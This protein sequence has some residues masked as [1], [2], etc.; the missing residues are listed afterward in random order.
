M[1]T[2]S[3]E[4]DKLLEE[5]EVLTGELQKAMR[6]ITVLESR[7][8]DANCRCKNVAGELKLIQVSLAALRQEKQKSQRQKI[9]AVQWLDHWKSRT[10]MSC[11][12]VNAPIQCAGELLELAEFSL[13]D[14][15]SA[16]CNFS[17]S[18]KIGEGGYGSV[19]KGEMLDRTVG[20]KILH[21]HSIHKQPEFY[22][23]VKC[24]V[25]IRE[26]IFFSL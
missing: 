1:R 17:E 2:I 20:I 11:A 21:R 22:Q 5:R 15:Q 26:F 18:F 24:S 6:N 12:N 4:R 7:A 14:I 9:E 8:Q 23:E 13:S 19:Y 10:Q 25:C 16:T 3:Q